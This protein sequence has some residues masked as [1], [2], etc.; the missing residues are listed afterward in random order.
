MI[1]YQCVTINLLTAIKPKVIMGREI[2]ISSNI[3]ANFGIMNIII[4]ANIAP[5]PR[6]D[7]CVSKNSLSYRIF[8]GIE[9]AFS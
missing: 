2:F 6:S 9:A 7:L 4:P 1:M 5:P 3:V 8:T